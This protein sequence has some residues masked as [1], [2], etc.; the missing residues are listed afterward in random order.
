M[1]SEDNN[2]DCPNG[3]SNCPIY[4]D[5][6]LLKAQVNTLNE[7]ILLDP[8]TGLFNKRH[9]LQSLEKEM[10][11]TQRSGQPTSLIM[12]DADHFKQVNDTYGHSA[13]DR[14]LRYIATTIQNETRKLDIPCRYGGEEFAIV[15]PT[16]PVVTA[17]HVAERIRATLEKALIA[18]NDQAQEIQITASLGVS[19]YQ[20]NNRFGAEDFINRSD[21]QLYQAKKSGR[22]Q[23]CAD[24]TSRP[25]SGSVSDAEREALFN[26]S[27]NDD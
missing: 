6:Q 16:T 18:I 26:A 3:K 4:Q 19:S 5:L 27:D 7:Q 13:G 2:I 8:L 14:V 21:Q 25:D 1:S 24:T 17:I 15:L 11:R 9:L 12:F 22:N 20:Q 23:V 10:E